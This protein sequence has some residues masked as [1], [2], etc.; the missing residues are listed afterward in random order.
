M[1]T[2]NDLAAEFGLWVIEDACQAHGASRNGNP[3]GSLGSAG[4][5]SF[6]P[7]KNMGA[8]GEGGMVTTSNETVAEKVFALR[9]HGQSSRYNHQFEG[10]NARLDAVQAGI[11]NEKLKLLPRWTETRLA[12][13]GTYQA[14]LAELED[15]ELP[16]TESRNTHVFHQFVI[17]TRQRDEL[18]R[19]LTEK[20]IGSA[21]HYPVPLHLQPAYH[22][23]GYQ[24]G[25]FP[26]AE[27]ASKEVLSLP[28]FEGLHEDEQK[29]V[30]SAVKDFFETV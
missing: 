17:R 2:I 23:L 10:L 11:L 1:D 8:F 25:A 21:V 15:I 13:A 5:F 26:C 12:M 20:G 3:A 18:R 7:T 28:L 19:H 14:A 29:V 30:I 27:S 24:P 22:E 9:N 16:F 4:A 6:Y